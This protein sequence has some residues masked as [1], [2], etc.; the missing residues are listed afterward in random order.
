M[1]GIHRYWNEYTDLG[2]A[3]LA[4]TGADL[5]AVLLDEL[6][7]DREPETRALGLARDVRIESLVDDVG[8]E[9]RA[10]VDHS[11]LH[12]VGICPMHAPRR[13]LDV[14]FGLM[15]HGLE[16]IAQKIVQHLPQPSG[17]GLDRR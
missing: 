7:D 13:D 3:L 1:A 10:V 11:D 16:R 8:N 2:S 14:G 12:G 6:L 9:A 4:V 15:L 17:V 5:A